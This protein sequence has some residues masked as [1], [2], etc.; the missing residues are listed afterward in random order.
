MTTAAPQQAEGESASDGLQK[1][2]V[3]LLLER[4]NKDVYKKYE[5]LSSIGQGSM[6]SQQLQSCG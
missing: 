5:I 2:H 3:N 1:P 6:V 4:K